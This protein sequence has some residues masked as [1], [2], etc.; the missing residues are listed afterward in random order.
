MAATAPPGLSWHPLRQSYAWLR[1]PERVVDAGVRQHGDV[2]SVRMF[3]SPIIMHASPEL[4]KELVSQPGDVLAAGRAND[5][6]AP[7]VG[8]ASL[9][10]LDGDE[11][12]AMRRLQLPPFH[13]ER[14]RGYER[15][16]QQLADAGVSR[17]PLEAPTEAWPRMQAITLD[18]II[19]VIFG[20]ED[21]RP[22]NAVRHAV[23]DLLRTGTRRSLFA[24]AGV[25]AAATG[26]RPAPDDLLLRGVARSRSRL[27]D[28]LDAEIRRRR[29]EGG[30]RGDVLSMLL[31]ATGPDG[32]LLPT[33][34]LRDQLVTLLVAGHETT[35]T[36]LSWAVERIA[37]H[38]ELQD[39]L[40]AEALD[41]RHA[42]I[43]A[44]VKEVL[45]LRP[46]LPLFM[47]EVVEACE[48]GGFRHEPGTLLAGATMAL[49][50]RH[51][52]YPDPSAFRPERF[53]GDDAPGTYAWT[54]FGGGV[55]RCL[56]ASFAQLEMRIVLSALLAERRL[57]PVGDR[58]EV[59]RRRSVV[60]AP[61][62]AGLVR[63][64]RRR[65]ARPQ[66]ADPQRSEVR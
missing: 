52:L 37:R 57:E 23:K 4:V 30:D 11:H 53:L 32:Q 42:L 17:W 31:E 54:P 46:V 61:S 9:L 28:L 39:R 20:I 41:G 8:S 58:D 15:A 5:I 27:A 26:K 62:K 47:R 64:P 18:I 21:D 40:A 55:R 2:F 48:I 16:M 45:R 10:L 12:L 49:H 6:L 14:M 63:A 33:E 66:P 29:D 44:T 13:G 51:D 65:A 22:R 38:P 50:R 56:G 25:K 35:A 1:H 19:R 43:D 3:G 7:M 36:A 24:A 34:V 60:L 59:I